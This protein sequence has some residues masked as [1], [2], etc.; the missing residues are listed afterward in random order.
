MLKTNRATGMQARHVILERHAMP[1]KHGILA[2]Q[3]IL[4]NHEIIPVVN[5][6]HETMPSKVR[7]MRTDPA[8]VPVVAKPV[9]AP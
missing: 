2:R 8:R 9:T 4:V 7:A 3:A 5:H 1:A 6:I